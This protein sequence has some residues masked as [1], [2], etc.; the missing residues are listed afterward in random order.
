MLTRE[1]KPKGAERDYFMTDLSVSRQSRTI[2]ST[3]GEIETA[4]V[5]TLAGISPHVRQ[6]F[7][8]MVF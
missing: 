6:H 8:C 5:I 1:Y 4:S 3:Q 2:R 7:R